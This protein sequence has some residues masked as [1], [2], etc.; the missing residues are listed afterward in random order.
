MLWERSLLGVIALAGTH[1]IVL[2]NHGEVNLKGESFHIEKSKINS[3]FTV[4]ICE[5][6]MYPRNQ[7]DIIAEGLQLPAV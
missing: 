1:A 6:R 7:E 2:E 4:F 3:M 5:H